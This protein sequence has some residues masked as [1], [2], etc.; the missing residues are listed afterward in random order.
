MLNLF[1]LT[2]SGVA[3][4]RPIIGILHMPADHGQFDL[5]V[6]L[7]DT[8]G[9][10]PVTFLFQGKGTI[11]ICTFRPFNVIAGQ[12]LLNGIQD[13]LTDQKVGVNIVSQLPHNLQH[14]GGNLLVCVIHAIVQPEEDS[15]PERQLAEIFVVQSAI[16]CAAFYAPNAGCVSVRGQI[17]NTGWSVFPMLFRV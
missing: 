2:I 11:F 7:L 1:A 6:I 14:I 5:A 8:Q 17:V 15:F 12:F 9:H 4:L 13:I 10:L 3:N 16:A